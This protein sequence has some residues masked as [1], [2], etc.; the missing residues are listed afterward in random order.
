MLA[1]II[2]RSGCC[3]LNQTLWAVV[4]TPTV[5]GTLARL[6][7]QRIAAAIGLSTAVFKRACKLGACLLVLLSQ[8]RQQS[9][10]RSEANAAKLPLRHVNRGRANATADAALHC[11]SDADIEGELVSRT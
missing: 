2:P 6:Q 8:H 11:L 9:R 10:R 3:S 1:D 5:L 7:M 4:L